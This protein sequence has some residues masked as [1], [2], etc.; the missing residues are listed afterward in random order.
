MSHAPSVSTAGDPAREP[1]TQRDALQ[2][3]HHDRATLDA[4]LAAVLARID[5]NLAVFTDA[6]PPP[7]IIVGVYPAIDNVEWTNGF[8]TGMLW[9]AYEVSGEARYRQ[10]AERQVR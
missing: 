7:S 4:V 1:L 6:F 9:L 10:A 3:R 5:A 2:G 8:W